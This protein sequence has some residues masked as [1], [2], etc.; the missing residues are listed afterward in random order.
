MCLRLAPYVNNDTDC[1]IPDDCSQCLTL[2]ESVDVGDRETRQ[3]IKLE[4]RDLPR[5]IPKPLASS[6]KDKL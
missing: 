5:V 4:L 3:R 2:W 6:A 1:Y